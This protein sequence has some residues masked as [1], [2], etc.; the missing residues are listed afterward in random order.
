M[1][2]KYLWPSVAVWVGLACAGLRAQTLSTTEIYAKVAES[3]VV[4]EARNAENVAIGQATA[5]VVAPGRLLTNAH[6][7]EGDSIW[8]RVGP[9]V[10]RGV[11]ERKDLANDL[12]LVRV[13]AEL[14]LA[15]L[16]F[17]T[18]MPRP[19]ARVFALGNPQGLERTIS[20]GLVTTIRTIRGQSVL[21]LSAAIS[22]GSSGGPVL[23]EVGEVVGVA[24]LSFRDA[25]NLNFAV[26]A[27]IADRFVRGES[28]PDGPAT[29]SM[30]EE[31]IQQRSAAAWSVDDG[32]A[33]Q[34]LGRKLRDAL[35]TVVPGMKEEGPLLA[36]F[37]KI[38][39]MESDVERVVARRAV[40]VAPKSAAAHYNLAWS[41]H[42]EA[43]SKEDPAEK[44]AMLRDA[45]SSASRAVGLSIANER[46]EALLLLGRIQV[47]TES[48]RD[49]GFVT[50]TQVVGNAKDDLSQQAAFVLYIGN[51]ESKRNP[52]ARKWF[53]FADSAGADLTDEYADF[54]EMLEAMD[55]HSAAASAF[56][57]A[58]ARP[59][60]YKYHCDA[61]RAYS[62]ADQLDR[63]IA[64]AR[65]CLEGASTDP[66]GN[67]S[68]EWANR[69]LSIMLLERGVTDQAISHARQA[70][71]VDGDS[72]AAFGQLA[73]SL[74][75]AERWS[76]A[77]SA[78]RNAI[79]LTDGRYSYHH[80]ALGGALFEQKRWSESKTAYEQAA[81]LNTKDA[82]A[83]YNVALCLMQLGFRTDA[84]YWYE[85]TLRRNP[86]IDE[87]DQIR[88]R[89]Q[90]L[91][92]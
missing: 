67:A 59:G 7:V 25:Q 31:L 44:A 10:I 56:L 90:E 61:A 35:S 70:I 68:A 39:L 16:T 37:E 79:R 74:N 82:A 18:E 76:E 1:L 9:V 36:L 26:P 13:S 17:A 24:T 77:E 85:E 3:V 65:K 6:A 30:L 43:V 55:D 62:N 19:G 88:R 23:N 34:Q 58:A 92:R 5:F 14:N 27:T 66:K 91:R 89:L 15:P 11:V 81:K 32:S 86:K 20:E 69:L 83:T 29:V 47:E 75:R 57:K 87:A 49:F 72:G 33:Y 2:R 38:K 78:A 50:L 42:A 64:A 73:I 80:F 84:I 51:K 41:L 21:Q 40:V 71:A 8:L 22:P 28:S 4:L 46:R 63:G 12:A 60:L 45:E 52:I 48:R 54:G 53:E